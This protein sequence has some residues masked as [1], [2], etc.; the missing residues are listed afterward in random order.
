[1]FCERTKEGAAETTAGEFQE[2]TKNWEAPVRTQQ[3][4]TNVHRDKTKMDRC[5]DRVHVQQDFLLFCYRSQ[6]ETYVKKL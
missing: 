4:G 2:E 5:P 6:S 3:K 1:M